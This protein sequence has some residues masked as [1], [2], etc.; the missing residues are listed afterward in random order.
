MILM[1]LKLQYPGRLALTKAGEVIV[2]TEKGVVP[3]ADQNKLKGP[4]PGLISAGAKALAAYEQMRGDPSYQHPI[5]YSAINPSQFEAIILPG[6]DALRMR[7]Y[8]DS[9]ELQ[10]K[11]LEFWQR[12]KLVGAICHGILVLART[13]DP[14]SGRSVLYGRKLTALPK[15]FDLM[16]YRLD[17]LLSK[18]GYIMYPK[19]VAEEVRTCLQHPTDFVSGPGLLGP[20]VVAEGNL[21]TSR[22]YM[23]AEVFANKFVEELKHRIRPENAIR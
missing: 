22:W 23:D 19:C 9:T 21:V 1:S 5:P 3:Q 8:L 6:G 18:H 12:G 13:I 14:Q 10:S 2:S 11:V 16:G 7:Q 15:T 20:F 4:L 17:S